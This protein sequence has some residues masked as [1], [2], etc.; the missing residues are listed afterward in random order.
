MENANTEKKK[1]TKV[2]LYLLFVF[3]IF[4]AFVAGT[5]AHELV[6]KL[7]FQQYALTED[8]CFF[9]LNNDGAVGYYTF[10]YNDSNSDLIKDY[11]NLAE[12]KAY[13]ASLFLIILFLFIFFQ[14][15]W[16]LD[17]GRL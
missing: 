5:M 1:G 3:G 10:S 17:S 14:V 13:G 6:H 4:G 7:D 9:G 2:L 8:V 15:E 16:R 12:I 11:K